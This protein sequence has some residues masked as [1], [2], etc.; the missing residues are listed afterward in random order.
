HELGHALAAMRL[1]IEMRGITLF[2]FGGVA[3][4]GSEPPNARA[5]FLVAIAGPIVSIGLCAGLLAASAIPTTDL[6]QAV[7][8][9][10]GWINGALVVF[11][12]LPAFPLD[13]G[14]VLR[15]VLW[16]VR[17]DLRWATRITSAI[18]TA[19]GYGLITLGIVTLLTTGELIVAVWWGLLGFFLR[20][21]AQG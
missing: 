12:M 9:Y 1:G 15:S 16:N 8:H 18:G 7:V 14:R 10:L 2:I 5:E 20:N 4:M 19:F 3:E 6:L 13:G 17:G 11:N 21:A